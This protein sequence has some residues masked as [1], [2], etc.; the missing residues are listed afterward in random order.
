MDRCVSV[1][2]FTPS[3]KGRRTLPLLLGGT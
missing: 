1:I 3:P 2:A